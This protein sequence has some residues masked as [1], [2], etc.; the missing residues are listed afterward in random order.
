MDD[1]SLAL[2]YVGGP[3]AWLEFGGLRFL[4]DPTFDPAGGEY[5]TGRVTL[6]KLAGPALSR[7]ALGGYDY[8]LLSHDHHSDNLDHAGRKALPD[9]KAVLTTCEGARRLGGNSIG[10]KPWEAIDLAT[11]AGKIV[12]VIATPARHGP[13]GLHR[14]EVCGFVLFPSNAPERAIYISGDT[15]WYEGVAQVAEQF[16]VRA[17]LLHLGA[18]RV[19]EV[20]TFHL[21]MTASEAVEAARALANAAI[22]PIHFEGWGHFSEGSREVA[23]AFAAAKL[24]H[25][26]HWPEPGRAIQI[27]LD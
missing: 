5:R 19:P 26:L 1:K 14:G 15:V 21:T 24:E 4:T 2:T 9:A 27:P 18:A 11:P 10:L 23:A 7:E 20:G 3:T 6:R 8:V 16:A 17:V 22:V 12:R 13:A 25:R